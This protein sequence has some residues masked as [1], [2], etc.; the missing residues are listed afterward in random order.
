MITQPTTFVV[1]AGASYEYGLPLGADLKKKILSAVNFKVDIKVSTEDTIL[2]QA[3]NKERISNAASLVDA[4]LVLAEHAF[5]YDSIDEALHAFSGNESV[6]Q[7][8]KLAIASQILSGEQ[9]SSLFD[10]ERVGPAR[11][12]QIGGWLPRL[13]SL[14]V[15]GLPRTR[16]PDAFRTVAIINFNYD[17]AIEHYLYG[18]VRAL[19]L[20]HEEA[21][22]TV[23]NLTMIRPYGSLGPLPWQGDHGVE[24]GK[25]QENLVQMAGTLRT[26]TE[27]LHEDIK[28]KIAM[29]L[30]QSAVMI[31]LGFGF[32][33]QNIQIMQSQ[34]QAFNGTRA[35]ATAYCV[36][37]L[38]YSFLRQAIRQ[39]LR[40]Y[41]ET[42][43]DITPWT[44]SNLFE[45]AWTAINQAVS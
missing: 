14:A 19:G 40:K 35:F 16:I 29:R 6:I 3:L 11:F 45:K 27:T 2:L 43:I 5:P 1:G 42:M 24:Y 38:N 37:E 30:D 8:G 44:C 17:R 20:P 12:A 31:Y 41:D 23:N 13:F 26:F 4:G 28:S 33:K 9:H 22:E 18:A 7:V 21:A 25:Y 10:K 36:D 15:N 32:H 34:S 39:S